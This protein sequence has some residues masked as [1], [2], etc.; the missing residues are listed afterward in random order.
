VR[1]ADLRDSFGALSG[2][3]IVGDIERA[4]DQMVHPASGPA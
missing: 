4:P 1:A 3:F 2:S